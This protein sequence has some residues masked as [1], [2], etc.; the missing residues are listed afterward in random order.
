MGR[1]GAGALALLASVL[2][3]VS[4]SAQQATSELNSARQPASTPA[5]TSTAPGTASATTPVASQAVDPGVD[6]SKFFMFYAA[7][8]A[9]DVARADLSYCLAL[10]GRTG[11]PPRTGYDPTTSMGL[12]GAL[13]GAAVHSVQDSALQ[14]RGRDASMRNCMRLHGYDRYAMAE[15]DWNT[16]MQ[17]P[18]ATDRM[19]AYMT[20]SQ[21][22]TER[23]P[24]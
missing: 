16:M 5:M 15:A 20:G 2:L 1:R 19:L 3:P 24:A 17:G 12:I 7:G 11:A 21:P 18:G 10:S 13:V 23:L 22:Q 6:R 9:P 8:I 14:R 4:A